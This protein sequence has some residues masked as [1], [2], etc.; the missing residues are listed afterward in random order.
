MVRIAEKKELMRNVRHTKNLMTNEMSDINKELARLD[1][2][3]A[4]ERERTAKLL[5]DASWKEKNDMLRR[6]SFA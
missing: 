6:V 1:V 5:I 2:A 4:A 3:G